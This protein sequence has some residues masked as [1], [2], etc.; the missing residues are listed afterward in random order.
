MFVCFVFRY[1]KPK[2]T[3]TS[4][5]ELL[6]KHSMFFN[7]VQLNGFLFFFS[8][9]FFLFF[10]FLFFYFIIISLSPPPPPPSPP[11]PPLS[12]SLSLFLS[13]SFFLVFQ[14]LFQWRDHTA[15][16]EDESTRFVLANHML[17]RIAEVIIIIITITIIIII[18]NII[19]FYDD[20]FLLCSNFF[21]FFN[22]SSFPPILM[23]CFPAVNLLCLLFFV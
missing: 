22:N 13:L 4:H 20:F 9:Y 16:T 8:Y 11:P 3:P 10:I 19:L 18:I 2:I 1:E 23:D 21:F 6:S 7:P 15:R 5:L 14:A 17:I 12:F